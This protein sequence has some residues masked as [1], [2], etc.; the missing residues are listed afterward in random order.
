M[1]RSEKRQGGFTLIELLVVIAIIA[2]LIGIL[3][4]ALGEARRAAKK[5]IC[6]SNQKQ[7][8]VAMG[9]Y[10]ADFA[11]QIASFSWEA[12]ITPSRYPDLRNA[13]SHQR[14]QMYQATDILRR[15]SGDD[16]IRPLTQRFPHRRLSHLILY[17][18]L[19]S[20]LPEESAA[21]P[22]DQVLRG[23]QGEPNS[24]LLDP[25]PRGT[26]GFDQYW[27]F[28]SSYQLVPAAYAYDENLSVTRTTI[29][30]FP[31]DHNLFYMGTLP[32][33]KRQLSEVTFPGAKV[34]WFDFFD[35]HTSK[36][37]FYHAHELAA[38]PT[39]LFDGSV[40]ARSNNQ[41]NNGFHP[42]TPTTIRPTLYNYA[43]G[44]LGFEA[45]TISGNAFDRVTGKYRWTRGGIRGVDFGSD[46]INTGQM[47]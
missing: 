21:C 8:A 15:L 24:T 4:P 44:I 37:E 30:Q 35:R 36:A 6:F 38:S 33:G 5:V 10:A 14:A 20:T 47:R 45:P 1:T 31:P 32:L 2:L 13:G 17:D 29:S 23:W 34:A 12:G 3:L 40:H 42:W 18:Y 39:A 16:T 27:R 25:R 28:T 26:R 19:S 9:T 11:N 22:E 41:I 7:L 46:E 43:P